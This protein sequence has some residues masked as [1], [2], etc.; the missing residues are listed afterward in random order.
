MLF[1]SFDFVLFFLPVLLC[2]WL[3]AKHPV[4]RDL[5][6][7]MLRHARS[8]NAVTGVE[9]PLVQ[10]GP[11]YWLMKPGTVPANTAKDFPLVP[12]YKSQWEKLWGKATC[13]ELPVDDALWCG[14][15]TVMPRTRGIDWHEPYFESQTS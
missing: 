3:L 10:A 1:A 4:A 7:A 15:Q 2:Y 5:S 9:V 13:A 12:D 14:V 8:L 6:G 11:P